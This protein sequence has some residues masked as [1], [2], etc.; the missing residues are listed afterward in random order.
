MKFKIIKNARVVKKLLPLL[1]L[2][3]WA[4]PA[5]TILGV[6]SSLAEGI[7]I[8]LF[9]PFLESLSQSGVPSNTGNWLVNFFAQLFNGVSP[10]D[11]L[12]VISA[13]IFGCVL[14]RVSISYS[15]WLLFSLLDARI[16]HQLRSRLFKQLLMVSYR[17]LE[18]SPSGK[19]LNTLSTETWRTN[20]AL[21]ISVRM[22][23]TLCM[24]AIYVTLL[25][26]ISWKFTLLV[27]VAM[28]MMSVIVRRLTHSVKSLGDNATLANAELAENMVEGLEG[29]M[30]IRSFGQ[31]PHK[32]TRFDRS[33]Q[34]VSRVFMKLNIISEVVNP[35]YEILS[36]ALLVYVLF[37]SFQSPKGLPAVLVFIFVLY[38]L[39]PK[40]KSLN[41][42]WVKLISLTGAVE[43]VSSL[44]DR[45]DKSY[46]QTGTIPFQ[47]LKNEIR[48]KKIIFC[49][50]DGEKP[51]LR[52]VSL[53][54]PSGKMTAL[55]GPSGA[56]K[57]T[58]IKLLLRLYEPTGGEIYVDDVLLRELNLTS[59]RSRIAT[60]SQK[61]F[62]FNTTVKENI[63][64]GRPEA[65]SEE[66]VIA[67]KNA[68]AH[69][70]IN[71]LPYDYE[72]KI[73]DRGVRLSPGQ[74]QRI[75]LARAILRDPEIL[76]LDEATNSL[77]SIS[78]QLIQQAI[79][80]FSKNRTVIVIA[81]RFSTIERADHVI[82]L[83]EGQVSE[84]GNLQ[85]LLR[86]NGL[87]ARLYELQYRSAATEEI[88]H[89]E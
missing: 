55:V 84:H 48:F 56:G 32:Q 60:V 1:R 59:W 49:Y 77:D 18:S 37:S 5:I 34:R 44:L 78:E 75:A 72:T 66:I 11:R 20:E 27:A 85:Q 35:V 46:L 80:K 33:S 25:L 2:Y 57:S 9:I 73:G 6:L 36:T 71:Q 69:H 86:H 41:K 43:E 30:V 87:F 52:N 13:C 89:R 40:I 16:S 17:F 4:I 68:D 14:L 38:R 83:D 24:T 63:A 65:T 88:L 10:D 23:V 19:L 64:I 50:N 15:Y 26:L 8:S 79:E 53:G 21:E 45:T 61:V 54:I 39:Q 22:L 7:G 70:F 81:H 29:M 67:A 62:L 28:S 51:A 76:I 82:V 3:P 12:L 74:Q 47:G 58:L 42:D 31:E